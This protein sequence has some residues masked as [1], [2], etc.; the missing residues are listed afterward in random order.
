MLHPLTL[1]LILDNDQ[2]DAH[3]IYF[4]I[5]LLHSSICFVHYMFIIRRLKFIDAASGIVLSVSGRPVYRM[6]TD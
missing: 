5:Y 3:L 1:T 2:L 6:A 4:T